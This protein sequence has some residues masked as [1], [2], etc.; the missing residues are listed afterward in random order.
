MDDNRIKNRL[1]KSSVI[2]KPQ[3]EY[4]NIRFRINQ[5][6]TKN[7]FLWTPILVIAASLLLMFISNVEYNSDFIDETKI[8]SSFESEPEEQIILDYLALSENL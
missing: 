2:K 5:P 8:F 3:D 4:E 1:Q 6:K 7:N